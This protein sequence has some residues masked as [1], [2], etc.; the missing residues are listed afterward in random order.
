MGFLELFTGKKLSDTQSWNNSQ[1]KG[2][3][4]VGAG[5]TDEGLNDLRGLQGTFQGYINN[6]GLTPDL[7]RQF[8]VAQGQLSDQYTRSGRS[9]NAALAQR[10]LQ[11]GG[12]LTP[13]A[14]AEMEKE[15]QS[16]A[17]EQ[18]FGASNN[19]A[20][21]KADMSFQA[22]KDWYGR[23]QSIADTIRSTGLTREQ[24]AL[25]A[26]LQ[27]AGLAQ[28]RRLETAKIFGRWI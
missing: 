1:L 28:N 26:R 2:M 6:G 19:L 25:A 13:E 14:I 20:L 4:N 5:Q 27:M 8:D 21:Q 11:S 3:Q 17:D 24:A 23:I 18:Y 10:R 22:T 9:L 12:Q 16:S 15:G 7:Q